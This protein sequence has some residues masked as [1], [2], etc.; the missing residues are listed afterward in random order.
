M[1]MQ[2]AFIYALYDFIDVSLAVFGNLRVPV[3]VNRKRDV[4]AVLVAVVGYQK[5][6]GDGILSSRT[7][8]MYML[9]GG[10][11]TQQK[12]PEDFR[13]FSSGI[14]DNEGTHTA[15]RCRQEQCQVHDFREDSLLIRVFCL[16]SSKGFEKAFALEEKIS[17]GVENLKT[18]IDCLFTELK[19]C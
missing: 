5:E 14:F 12:P 9:Y 13:F 8:R 16:D 4:L 10:N 15:S 18:A 3:D 11:R 1:T 6:V 19:L 2:L 17:V 7:V